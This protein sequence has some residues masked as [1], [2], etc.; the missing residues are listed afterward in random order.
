MEKKENA[1]NH[2]W[3]FFNDVIVCMI[4]GS[5]PDQKRHR[6]FPYSLNGEARKWLF[7]QPPGSLASWTD[8]RDKFGARFSEHNPTR[9]EILN[10][11]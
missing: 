5:T 2:I 4:P 10:F 1:N 11:S 8:P 9:K 6:L 3:L 7:Q